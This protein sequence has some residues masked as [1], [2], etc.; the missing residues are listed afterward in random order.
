LTKQQISDLYTVTEAKAQYSKA[1]F[2]HVALDTQVMSRQLTNLLDKYP[3]NTFPSNHELA[4]YSNDPYNTYSYPFSPSTDV[5]GYFAPGDA[6]CQASSKC[7]VYHNAATTRLT[8]L[9]DVQWKSVFHSRSS[10][11]FVQFGMESNGF[12]RTYP[13]AW[14]S[15]GEPTQCYISYLEPEM[16]LYS[17]QNTQCSEGNSAPY[18]AYDP[19][20]RSWYGV[21]SQGETSPLLTYF[22][23]PRKASNGQFVVTAVT[24]LR[25]QNSASG[26]KLGVF[27]VNAKATDLSD[28][29]NSFKILHS[30]YVYLLNAQNISTIILHPRASSTCTTLLCCEKGFSAEEYSQFLSIVSSL[31]STT[32]QDTI[33]SKGGRNWLLVN[34]GFQSDTID[35]LVLA[36]VPMSEILQP[37][38][39]VDDTIDSTVAVII[40]V[41]VII[42]CIFLVFIVYCI[43]LLIRAIQSP[44]N[45]LIGLC[46]KII[47]N[48]LTMAMITE[49]IQC[50]DMKILLDTFRNIV[51]VLRFG[52]EAYI[53]GDIRKALVVYS[54]ALRLYE[55]ISNE[56]GISSCHNNLGGIYLTMKDFPNSEQH[57]LKSISLATEQL[58]KLTQL[59]EKSPSDELKG[60]LASTAQTLSD[61]QANLSL[62][63]IEQQKY[64]EAYGLLES[65]LENDM[66]RGYINGCVNKQGYLGFL[67]LRQKEVK[68]AEQ[69]FL[70]S[71][72]F[73]DNT[74]NQSKLLSEKWT[75]EELE[76]SKQIALF[77]YGKLYE[78]KK[79]LVLAIHYYVMSVQF[80]AK[81]HPMTTI[82]ALSRLTGIYLAHYP[83]TPSSSE[84]LRKLEAICETHKIS[85]KNQGGSVKKRLAIALDYS[86]SMSGVKIRSAVENIL[87]LFEDQIQAQDS[88][89][90]LH[91]NTSVVVD[92]PF[93][94]KEGNEEWIRRT[95]LSLVHPNSG[96]AL[97]DAMEQCVNYINV[98]AT[99]Q[100]WMVVLTDGEDTGS[101]VSKEKI[102]NSIS[103][104]HYGVILIGVGND[105]NHIELEKLVQAS[106]K[107]YYVKAAG[108]K[109]GIT[110]AFG[111]VRNLMQENVVFEDI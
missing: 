1:Y 13:Y 50:R 83:S 77:N 107:G 103:Q 102:C 47:S 35:Y 10:I 14:T 12:S 28:S 23:E 46:Q 21:G 75:E 33:Y 48:D 110:R 27:N 87:S 19:R 68:S 53:S 5:S 98:G 40:A 89:L 54:E 29:V 71:L 26:T 61:R 94:L 84:D 99:T 18:P 34:S 45:H 17:Y 81:M 73:L 2:D 91:F 62:L 72:I 56:K 65:C 43:V 31:S 6:N 52:N 44:I 8:S 51:I 22:Q 105:V 106:P 76:V 41:S 82:K 3:T 57:Y 100:D 30:G 67:Y 78:E 88:I 108:D 70:N 86:G 96:T 63:L 97:Y 11:S 90:L 24:P 74:H 25:S 101:R 95:I 49:E 66:K 36:T 109:D 20:C 42:F 92:L 58:E 111:Q 16:C 80:P 104:G 55:S 32:A 15:Y 59:V 9:V 60:Q 4:S 85:Y 38:R 7:S 64:P 93:T 79:D 37:S 69:Q 39:D